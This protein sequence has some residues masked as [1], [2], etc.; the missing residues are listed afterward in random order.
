[1]IAYIDAHMATIN[2]FRYPVR[3][4]TIA[5]AIINEMECN[6]MIN[7]PDVITIKTGSGISMGD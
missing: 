5:N 7:Y 6:E 2:T 1:M 3:S 4:L